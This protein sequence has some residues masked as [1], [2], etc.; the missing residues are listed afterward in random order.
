LAAVEPLDW[1]RWIG[2]ATLLAGTFVAVLDNF[3]VFVAIPSIRARLG[4]SFAEAQLVIAAYTLTYA[5]GLITG[6]RLG[7]RFGRRRMF[8]IGFAAFTIAS[9][10]CGIAPTPQTLILSRIVQGLSAAILSPQVLTLIRVTFTDTRQRATAFAWMG[11]VI[12][13]ASVLGQIVGGFIIAA[14]IWDLSWR[15]VF[16]INLPIGLLAMSVTP[17]VIKES[18]APKQ[19]RLDIVGS[20]LCGLGLG[21]LLYPLIQGREAGWPGWSFAML[22][23]SVVVLS[24]F[25]V[26]QNYKSRRNGSPLLEISLFHDRSFTIGV[27]LMLLFYATLSPLFLSFTYLVQLGFGR[28]PLQAALD[29]S[30]LAITFAVTSLVASRLTRNG[31]RPVLIAGAVI[32]MIGAVAAYVVCAFVAFP[33]PAQLIPALILLGAGEG[34]F[35]TPITNAVLSGIHERH[36]GSASGVLTTVQRTGNALGIAVLQIPFYIA[37]GHSRAAGAST[38]AAYIEAFGSVAAWVAAVL[39]PVIILVFLLPSGRAIEKVS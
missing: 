17:Y 12:G 8:L 33:K 35:M 6:G 5:I 30:P 25:Y 10:L 1:R 29:F 32:S 26:Q 38:A 37:L 9:G 14:N 2:L 27:L 39:I 13:A 15:P 21:L 16:L 18:H 20:A 34:L 36:A 3:V 11:V 22:G 28:S 4:A 31:A 19:H 24:V 23:A 7:D